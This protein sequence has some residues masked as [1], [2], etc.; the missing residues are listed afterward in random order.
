M[1]ITLSCVRRQVEVRAGEGRWA[2]IEKEGAPS[3]MGYRS[4]SNLGR[5][6]VDAAEAVE[7]LLLA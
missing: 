6:H 5:A 1:V 7:A 3:K 4:L 2:D